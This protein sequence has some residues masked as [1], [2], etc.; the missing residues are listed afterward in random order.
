MAASVSPRTRG[1]L[2]C[3]TA[4]PARTVIDLKA[5]PPHVVDYLG[6]DHFPEGLA[7][8]PTGDL[9]VASALNG[10]GASLQVSRRI[11]PKTHA[12]RRSRADD[13]SGKQR[14]ELADVPNQCCDIKDHVG[15]GA[16]L[17]S[18]AVDFEP[19]RKSTDV[20]DL[21]GCCEEG[22][23]RSESV[24]TLSFHP[25]AASLQLKAALGIVVVQN[26]TR[27]KVKRIFAR[28][29]KRLF[30]NYHGNF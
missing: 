17:P 5:T 10:S 30:A 22:A 3:P 6:V 13:I 18:L 26:I 8:N 2:V 16:I 21:I 29:I 1:T 14:H 15:P 9:A 28:D 20:G 4:A 11:H 7:I 12:S 24:C 27:H 19:H 25:L 23:Q